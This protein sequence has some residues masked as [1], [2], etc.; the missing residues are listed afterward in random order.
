MF[1]DDWNFLPPSTDYL[2]RIPPLQDLAKTKKF[3]LT[4]KNTYLTGVPETEISVSGTNIALIA[5]N[6]GSPIYYTWNKDEN[7]FILVSP[8]PDKDIGS[9]NATMDKWFDG[10]AV[11]KDTDSQAKD[12]IVYRSQK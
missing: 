1:E 10:T 9:S 12:N 11:Y 4:A 6:Y 2:I 7:S 8:G 5:D 3:T